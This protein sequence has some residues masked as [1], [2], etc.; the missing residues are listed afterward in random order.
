MTDQEHLKQWFADHPFISVS[1]VS[2]AIGY[3]RRVLS[4]IF[5][6]HRKPLLDSEIRKIARLLKKYGY[7]EK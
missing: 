3:D 1:A 5:S 6:G 4:E 7:P 2:K